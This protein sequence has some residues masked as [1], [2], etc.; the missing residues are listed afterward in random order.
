MVRTSFSEDT[1][2]SVPT[3]Y[4]SSSEG[5]NRNDGF[6][7]ERAA[8]FDPPRGGTRSRRARRSAPPAAWRR[9]RRAAGAMGAIREIGDGALRHRR[10]RGR[11][12]APRRDDARDGHRPARAVR[13]S[14]RRA[15]PGDLLLRGRA[16][17]GRGGVWPGEPVL[18]RR[19]RLRPSGARFVR[20]LPNRGIRA[21]PGAARRNRRDGEP[22]RDRGRMCG[23]IARSAGRQPAGDELPARRHLAVRLRPGLGAER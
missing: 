13:P 12:G 21:Q 18:R 19:A 10:I 11:G 14:A 7:P 4:V 16:R 20:R 6:L 8:R 2:S 1:T 9:L 17:R 22:L 23:R 15:R 5:H 3:V